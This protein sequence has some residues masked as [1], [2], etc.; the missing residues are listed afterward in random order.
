MDLDE[1][2]EGAVRLAKTAYPGVSLGGAFKRFIEEKLEPGFAM[3][4][5]SAVR[6]LMQSSEAR[7]LLGKN[8]AALTEV[9]KY[10]AMKNDTLAEVRTVTRPTMDYDEFLMMLREAGL[11][12]QPD[13]RSKKVSENRY[14]DLHEAT[15]H[16]LTTTEVRQCFAMAQDGHSDTADGEHAN[17][18]EEMIFSEFLEV[19]AR[20]A[21][22][23]WDNPQM[24]FIQKLEMVVEAILS[25]QAEIPD[26][27]VQAHRQGVRSGRRASFAKVEH[28]KQHQ[29]KFKKKQRFKGI[30]HTAIMGANYDLKFR[31][32]VGAEKKNAPVGTVLKEKTVVKRQNRKEGKKALPPLRKT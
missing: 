2:I 8:V 12:A 22:A 17:G 18:T 20:V 4:S 30:L 19:I 16:S 13:A 31:G 1:F 23:K 10:F 6:K 21:T 26:E 29:L 14:E 3:K 9:Y 15:A 32:V 28:N 5:A 7:Q 11:L 24:L 27:F 25:I